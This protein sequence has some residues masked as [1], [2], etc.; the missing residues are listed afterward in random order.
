MMISERLIQMAAM[1]RIMM[2]C[3]VVFCCVTAFDNNEA[4]SLPK[5][6][7]LIFLMDD[8]GWK[9]AECYGSRF[10]ETPVTDRLASEGMRFTDAYAAAPVC[11]PTRASIL[12]GQYPGRINMYEVTG[13]RERPYA[14]MISPKKATELPESLQT[15]AEILSRNGYTCGQTGKWH[16][17]R[18][19]QDEGFVEMANSFNDPELVAM[20]KR[21]EAKRIGKITAEALQF[22]RDH[23]DKPFVLSVDH[24]AVHAPLRAREELI[25]K[26]HN[27]LKK[28]GMLDVHPAYAAMTEMADESLGLIL[29]ELDRLGVAENTVVIF[30][31]DNGGLVSDMY[32]GEPTPLAASMKP[33]RSQKGDLYEGGIRIPLI[34]RWPGIVEKGSL[35]N[36]L[37][38]TCDLFA[39]I[40]DIT[41]VTQ[42][43]GQ[44][45]DGVSLTPLLRQTG[46]LDR[47][48]LYWHFPTSQWT[49][50]PGGAIRKGNYK[51]IEFFEDDHVELYD[52]ASD[53]G[54]TI[55]LVNAHPDI[56]DDLL[57]DL[58]RWRR[59]VNA[60]MPSPNPNYDPVREHEVAKE[61]WSK[62]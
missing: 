25:K 7:I 54:E 49:R 14:K 51:L 57:Q 27:K 52:L 56:A 37:V 42:P 47:E 29:T 33:L 46:S 19:P 35:S 41:G 11:S 4:C 55:D 48:T 3:L 13:T 43:A 44:A 16:V 18:T 60:Q 34:V 36:M 15:F 40:M 61:Y 2:A 17:G 30:T 8:M 21:N 5:P 39:T 1:I 45:V 59:S 22:L 20:V 6:N 62:P 32:L 10:I 26:Y 23:G 58:R 31:S 9:D 12:T 53:I 50:W 28:T 24:H 38:N